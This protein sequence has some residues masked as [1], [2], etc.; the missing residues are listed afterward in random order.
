ML[1][2]NL[3]FLRNII[4][5]KIVTDKIYLIDKEINGGASSNPI[6]IPI[7]VEP[8]ITHKRIYI[9]KIIREIMSDNRIKSIK[10][11]DKKMKIYKNINNIEKS[12]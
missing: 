2:G 3:Y 12:N 7:Q 4:E 8:Q 10:A 5:Y 6:L 1:A 9:H 11:I